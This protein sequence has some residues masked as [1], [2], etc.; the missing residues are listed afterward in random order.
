M[1]SRLIALA[2]LASLLAASAGCA[3]DSG[4]V[5]GTETHAAE[6]EIVAA[7]AGPSRDPLLVH[8]DADRK[9]TALPGEATA[10]FIEY[11]TGGQWHVWWT[12][13]A[14]AAKSALVS[15][16]FVHVA[17]ASESELSNTLYDDSVPG[18]FRSINSPN[19]RSFEAQT[20]TNYEPGGVSFSSDRG[21]TIE[22]TVTID[23]KY[24]AP[25]FFVEDGKINGGYEGPLTDPLRVD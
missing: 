15:G 18:G 4:P 1:L 12:C 23:G 6:P 10:V 19:P 16:C 25:F 3:F 5:D 7:E 21:A 9:L 24:V 17:I 2:S 11:G 13:D 22:I 8:V 20:L 14:R